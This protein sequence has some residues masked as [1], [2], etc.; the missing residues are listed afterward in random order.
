MRAWAAAI[1]ALGLGLAPAAAQQQQQFFLFGSPQPDKPKGDLPADADPYYST[2]GVSDNDVDMKATTRREVMDPTHEPPG[3]LTISTKARKLW[4]SEDGGQALE[5]RIAV[6]G[7]WPESLLARLDAAP[8][9][10]RP[11]V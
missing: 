11:P 10:D 6:G 3:T 2:P 4:L 7:D 1:W 8:R 5:Y 9:D